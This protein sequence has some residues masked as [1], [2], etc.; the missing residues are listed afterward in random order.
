MDSTIFA[1]G[2]A[3]GPI[4][5][6]R[7]PAHVGGTFSQY[8]WEGVNCADPASTFTAGEVDPTLYGGVG[9]Y[10]S[11]DGMGGGTYISGNVNGFLN[12]GD[13]NV[14]HGWYKTRACL[15]FYRDASEAKRDMIEPLACGANKNFAIQKLGS[16]GTLA[17]AQIVNDGASQPLTVTVSGADVTIHAAT[18]SGG[19]ITSTANAVIT[20]I[21][22]T[23]ASNTLVSASLSVEAPDGP[24]AGGTCSPGDGTGLVEVTAMR[25]LAGGPQNCPLH[26]VD[27]GYP[28]TGPGTTDLR[29]A[30][31]IYG[32]NTLQAT[33]DYSPNPEWVWLDDIDSGNVLMD[34]TMPEKEP[35]G[36]PVFDS[37]TRHIYLACGYERVTDSLARPFINVFTIASSLPSPDPLSFPVGTMLGLGLV[38][39]HGLRQRWSRR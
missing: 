38:S 3:P 16:F 29:A 27:M 22:T 34:R 37:I 14:G 23:P 9:S 12:I 6:M 30:F 31:Q 17:R 25:K 39:G 2:S 35:C 7:R 5:T 24:Q 36:S 33:P 15:D 20:A 32:M 18:N 28:V 21:N 1:A 8:S 26:N 4:V 10:T 19:V 11:S 13:F